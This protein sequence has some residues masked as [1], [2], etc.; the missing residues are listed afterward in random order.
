MITKVF[1]SGFQVSNLKELLLRSS[2]PQCHS[3]LLN[4]ELSSNAKRDLPE[5]PTPIIDYHEKF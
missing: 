1:L 4:I 5:A 2:H 3:S